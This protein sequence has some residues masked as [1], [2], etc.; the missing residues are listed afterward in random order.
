MVEQKSLE[1]AGLLNR[2]ELVLERLIDLARKKQDFVIA[3]DCGGLERVLAEEA[4]ALGDLEYLEKQF[5]GRDDSCILGDI[6]KRDEYRSAKTFLTEKASLL[7]S[8]NDQNQR[9][10][11]K[12][13][14]IVKY[15]L[16][17][18]LPKDDYFNTSEMAPIAFDQKV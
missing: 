5:G 3:G 1:V 2:L 9:L 18:F 16:G 10:I 12:S 4:A 8:I 6:L 14:E 13:L 15:E 11:S 17:L 7:R